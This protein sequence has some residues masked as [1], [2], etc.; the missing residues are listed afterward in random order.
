ME[1][2]FEVISKGYVPV[3]RQGKLTKRQVV[4]EVVM[5]LASLAGLVLVWS[6]WRAPE[7]LDTAISLQ[8]AQ[9][10]V[11]AV[12]L[13][14]FMGLVL[15]AMA[16]RLWRAY[17][18][19]SALLMAAEVAGLY[20]LAVTDPS[21]F[22]HLAVFGG[23]A[24][25]SASWLAVLALDLEDPWLSVVAAVGVMSVFTIP[26]SL[27]IGERALITS[28]LTGMNLMFFRHFG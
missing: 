27:G 23:V 25:A 28:C 7:G 16:V 21:S 11:V 10:D 1:R 17:R 15:L 9:G 26:L 3:W 13:F 5:V 6:P 4:T 18:R 24:L 20:C 12:A 22:E 19:A 8:L 14:A 2:E